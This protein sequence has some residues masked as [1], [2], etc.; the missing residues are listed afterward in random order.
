MH[1]YRMESRDKCE[2]V[3]QQLNG[4]PCK[5]WKEPLLVKFAD[6]GNKKRHHNSNHQHHHQHHKNQNPH[7]KA[8]QE[9]TRWRDSSNASDLGSVSSFEQQSNI[10]HSNHLSDLAMI[11]PMSYPRIQPV[12]PPNVTASPSYP[13]QLVPPTSA[14]PQ[15][16]HPGGPGPA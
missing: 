14:A 1:H 12:F 15:W 16:I 13:A 5:G 4:R 9:D 3:I 8:H 2:Q 7:H 11:G 6:G 10:S